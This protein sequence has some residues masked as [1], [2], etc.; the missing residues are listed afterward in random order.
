LKAATNVHATTRSVNVE[1]K[2][3]EQEHGE[4]NL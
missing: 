1:N 3:Q 2:K 4:P